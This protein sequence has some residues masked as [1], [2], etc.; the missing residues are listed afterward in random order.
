MKMSKTLIKTVG[1]AGKFVAPITKYA[2]PI[3]GGIMAVVSDIEDK[4]QKELIKELAD[5]VAKLELE[6]MSK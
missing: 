4:K 2:G 6:K 1:K 5:R 3:V